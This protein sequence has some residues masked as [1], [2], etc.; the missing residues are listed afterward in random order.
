[1]Q[2]LPFDPIVH[3]LLPEA[4]HPDILLGLLGRSNRWRG[5]LSLSPRPERT[6]QPRRSNRSGLLETNDVIARLL[7]KARTGNHH[8]IYSAGSMPTYSR[9]SLE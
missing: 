9:K 2:R 3:S 5:P 1:M 7:T 6:N 8:N 4:L